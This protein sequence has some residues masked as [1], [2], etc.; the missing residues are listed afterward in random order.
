MF[1]NKIITLFPTNI[2]CANIIYKMSLELAK[3]ELHAELRNSERTDLNQ[4]RITLNGS[5]GNTGYIDSSGYYI[6]KTNT[7]IESIDKKLRSKVYTNPL[8]Y[9]MMLASDCNK[10]VAEDRQIKIIRL[11]RYIIERGSEFMDWKEDYNA[12]Y[13]ATIKKAFSTVEADGMDADLMHYFVAQIPRRLS[14]RSISRPVA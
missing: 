3:I 9:V 8:S 6:G 14:N 2:D 1:F 13:L 7:G 5:T 12:F 4:P 10:A 11:Y